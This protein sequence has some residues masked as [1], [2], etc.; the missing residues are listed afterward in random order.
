MQQQGHDVHKKHFAMWIA[1][2]GTM[3]VIVVLWLLI[4]PMQLREQR[5]TGLRGATRWYTAE[6]GWAANAEQPSFAE[7]LEQQRKRLD[8]IELNTGAAA[9][10][11]AKRIEDLRAKIEASNGTNAAPATN[12][13]P[14]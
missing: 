4:L 1:V 7:I 9:G 12:Q 5:F 8:A 14:Q 11:N 3:A 10:G 2:G 13:N 6:E